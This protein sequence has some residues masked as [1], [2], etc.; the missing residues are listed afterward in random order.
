MS[1]DEAVASAK[2]GKWRF[3]T[4]REKYVWFLAAKS[5]SGREYIRAEKDWVQ[6]ITLLSPT[7]CPS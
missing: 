4:T 7:D 2:E 3:W 6:P 1:E 5:A